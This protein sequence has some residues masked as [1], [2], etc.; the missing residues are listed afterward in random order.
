L[1]GADNRHLPAVAHVHMVD[2]PAP[3]AE[4]LRRLAL[5]TS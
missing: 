3:W 4:T 5:P 2:H 1:P